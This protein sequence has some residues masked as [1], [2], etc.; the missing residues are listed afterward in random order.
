MGAAHRRLGD[1][2]NLSVRRV[3]DAEGSEGHRQADCQ[4]EAGQIQQILFRTLIGGKVNQCAIGDMFSVQT[5][6]RATCV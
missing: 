5:F 4:K 2:G 6:F 3:F 1:F